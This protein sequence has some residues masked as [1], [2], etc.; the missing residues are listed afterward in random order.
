MPASLVEGRR[1]LRRDEH[2]IALT[3]R[4]GKQR[5]KTAKPAE[6]MET[7]SQSV[8]HLLRRWNDGDS[9]ALDQLMP[10]VYAELRLMARRYMVQ[11]PSGH[12][13]QTTA[14]IHEAYLRLVGQE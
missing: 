1:L 13:L 5:R 10:L 9:E 3:L 8:S 14:L 2:L 7:S 6:K 4:N 11:Q 12:T